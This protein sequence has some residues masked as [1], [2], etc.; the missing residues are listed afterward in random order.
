MRKWVSLLILI[1][2]AALPSLAAAQGDVH[3]SALD[4]KLWPE[5]DQPDMLVIYD[6]ELTAQTPLP[7]RVTFLIPAGVDVIAV[8]S[9]ENGGLV[10]VNYEGPVPAGEWQQ[11]TILVDKNTSYHFEYYAPILTTDALRSFSFL[12]KGD[13]AVDLL[14]ISV[15]QPPTAT[16][17]KGTPALAASVDTD[18]LTYHSV[19]A[20]NLKPGEPFNLVLEYN[21]SDDKLTAPSSVIEPSTPLTDETT[22]RVLLNNYIPYL[23]GGV[24]LVLI[25][26]G[27]GYYFLFA[28]RSSNET[29]R[30]RRR[31]ASADGLGTSK[32]VYCSQCGERAR[33]GDRFCRTCGTRIR[34][35]G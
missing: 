14:S 1:L 10:N 13:Y 21:K 19:Q 8:A 30:R 9:L 11:L 25:A 26:S 32:D 17:L 22:G 3:I 24:G 15:Q 5:Y 29:T 35:A 16:S 28:R 31:P 23:I 33:P 18:G 4:I 7:A 20:A 6:F 34:Q 2:V 12:W 27:V